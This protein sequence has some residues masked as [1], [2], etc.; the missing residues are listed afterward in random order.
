[1]SLPYAGVSSETAMTV[2][3]RCPLATEPTPSEN[4]KPVG[5]A[6]KCAW[7]M[8]QTRQQHIRTK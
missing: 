2:G 7:I 4:P 3:R 6:L 5:P 1:M 8:Y